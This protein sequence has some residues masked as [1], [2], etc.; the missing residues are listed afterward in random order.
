ML[1]DT[2]LSKNLQTFL[3]NLKRFTLTKKE[4]FYDENNRRRHILANRILWGDFEMPLKSTRFKTIVKFS[5]LT[6]EDK[7]PKHH[8]LILSDFGILLFTV[9]QKVKKTKKNNFSRFTQTLY[10][11]PWLTLK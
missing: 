5:R 6:G 2:D 10:L 11:C 9:N 3:M 4:Q 1:I 8:K 7:E